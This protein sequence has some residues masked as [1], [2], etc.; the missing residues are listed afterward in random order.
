MTPTEPPAMTLARF[1][2]LLDVYG[3]RI[4]Q[5]PAAER[6]AAERLAEA[7]PEAQRLL[8]S[9]APLD[10]W[11]ETYAVEEVSPRLMARVLEVPVLAERK[12]RRFGFRLAWA[13][14]FSCLVGLASG[15]LTAP[16]A[17]ADDDEWAELTEVS[18][19]SDVDSDPDVA[20]EEVP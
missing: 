12:Q 14:A 11:L 13:V 9:D 3:G 5:W 19:Y 8:A 15:V 7:N 17:S 1:T 2:E 6:A 16:E 10:A 18:F 20:A 4:S